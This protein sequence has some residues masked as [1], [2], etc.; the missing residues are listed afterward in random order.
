MS[1]F[2][3]STGD[4]DVTC[5]TPCWWEGNVPAIEDMVRLSLTW[6][7]PGCGREWE[8]LKSDQDD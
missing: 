6:V 2:W 8:E 3:R 5:D 4:L 1:G 7:C